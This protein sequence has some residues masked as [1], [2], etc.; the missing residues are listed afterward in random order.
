MDEE[1]KLYQ[2][3]QKEFQKSVKRSLNTKEKEF[4]RWMAEKALSKKG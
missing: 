1:D 3:L 4:I 2:Q